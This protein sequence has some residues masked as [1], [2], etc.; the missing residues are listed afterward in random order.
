[1]TMDLIPGGG[2][3][4]IGD[5]MKWRTFT[6]ASE[7]VLVVEWEGMDSLPDPEFRPAVSRSPRAVFPGSPNMPEG[8]KPNP[9]PKIYTEGNYHICK[10]PMTAGGEYTTVWTVTEF[11]G[12]KRL[13]LSIGYSQERTDTEKDA[14][15]DIERVTG[16]R[17]A[18]AGKE[19]LEWWH[20]FY[21]RS[22]ASVGETVSTLSSG[23]SCISWGLPPGAT[24]CR[25]T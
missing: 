24:V 23:A 10:Q 19:H 7:N 8:C 14:I 3:R 25:L 22:F 11:G 1:M 2:F 9:E 15:R 17:F 6:P 13:V 16:E 4:T 18:Q 5:R 21:A 20:D 12:K